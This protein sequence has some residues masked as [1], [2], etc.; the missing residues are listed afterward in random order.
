MCNTVAGI[1][2]LS[3]SL[4]KTVT[5]KFDLASYSLQSKCVPQLELTSQAYFDYSIQLPDIKMFSFYYSYTWTW[6]SNKKNISKLVALRLYLKVNISNYLMK[7]NSFLK[8]FL[9]CCDKIATSVF[10]ISHQIFQ[11]LGLRTVKEGQ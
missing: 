8:W 11:T 1:D 7:C 10:S 9:I 6:A 4:F 2:S 3:R 5:W